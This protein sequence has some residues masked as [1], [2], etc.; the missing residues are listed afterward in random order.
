MPTSKNCFRIVGLLGLLAS[1]GCTS[2]TAVNQSASL[3]PVSTAPAA[4][5][6]LPD[7]MDVASVARD[8]AVDPTTVQGSVITAVAYASPEPA[9]GGLAALNN[10]VAEAGAAQATSPDQAVMVVAA[11]GQPNAS[12]QAGGTT[13]QPVVAA[14]APV[15][16]PRVSGETKLVA[17][18]ITNPAS[19]AEPVVLAS[20]QPTDTGKTVAARSPELDSLIDRYAKIYE[21][22][23]ALVR[24]VVKR[25]ST[26]N[27]AARNGPYWGLMQIRHDTAKGLGYKGSAKG[28]LNAE[29]NLTYAVKY[30]KGAYV[31]AKG[32]H[33]QAVRYYS[34]GYYYDAKKRGLLVEAG[35][36][37]AKSAAPV[38]VAAAE[39]AAQKA[40]EL[41]RGA[42]VVV[43][44]LPGVSAVGQSAMLPAPSSARMAAAAPPASAATLG[45]VD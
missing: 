44:G 23:V 20:L 3:A 39:S 19:A 40:A 43:Q 34:R 9:S 22:P 10:A 26:F 12:V 37:K 6:G 45:M 36:K 13:V 30:L 25:E 18:A 31:T 1:A 11:S 21:V 33:D 38:Q 41:D 32:D 42:R 27:P 28:L 35:L 14:V 4:S 2:T 29:T 7:S 5:V 16:S 24:R 15:Q 17:V 8:T